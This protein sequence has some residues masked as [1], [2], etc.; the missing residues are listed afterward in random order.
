M[1][2]SKELP[3]EDWTNSA[4]LTCVPRTRRH[5]NLINSVWDLERAARPA[6]PR[7]E[8]AQ[9]LF[10]DISQN[11]NAA[12]WSVNELKTGITSQQLYHF[13]SDRMI[14]PIE[15]FG[16]L[17]FPSLDLSGIS[18][19]ECR[20]LYGESFAVPIVSLLINALAVSISTTD[21]WAE[22]L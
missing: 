14:F 7:E 1:K 4:F 19:H 12:P 15:L 2:L 21:L 3:S 10:V 20:D 22:G 8:L 17:G 11:L 16:F 13:G 5:L 18:D 6:L 9:S